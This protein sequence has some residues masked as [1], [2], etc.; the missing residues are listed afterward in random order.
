MGGLI[1]SMDEM[2]KQDKNDIWVWTLNPK[3]GFLV[4]DLHPL[5]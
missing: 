1:S 2:V 4:Y 3:D 5:L